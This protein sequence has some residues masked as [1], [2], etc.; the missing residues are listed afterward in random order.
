MQELLPV[1]GPI[2]GLNST[3]FLDQILN[4]L[5]DRNKIKPLIYLMK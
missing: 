3:K 2:V 1:T 5:Q 4:L